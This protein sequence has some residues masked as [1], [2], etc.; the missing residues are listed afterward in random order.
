M[1]GQHLKIAPTLKGAFKCFQDSKNENYCYLM[2]FQ[3]MPFTNRGN[4]SLILH[5]GF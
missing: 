3:E 5:N 1:I 4:Y 2:L